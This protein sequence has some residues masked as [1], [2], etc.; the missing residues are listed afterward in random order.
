M[1]DQEAR[2]RYNE[3]VKTWSE[4]WCFCGLKDNWEFSHSSDEH[5]NPL[6]KLACEYG[7]IVECLGKGIVIFG[8]MP[9]S[10]IGSNRIAVSHHFFDLLRKHT[11]KLSSI[12][13]KINHYSANP[14]TDGDD[15]AIHIPSNNFSEDIL[16]RL[17]VL[18]TKMGLAALPTKETIN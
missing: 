18:T 6:E 12:I 10:V 2:Q 1:E 8:E 5:N 11:N 9:T 3:K 15:D 17:E 4:S 14:L 16:K 13:S 7:T